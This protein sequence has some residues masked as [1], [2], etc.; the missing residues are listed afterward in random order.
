M[1][2]TAAA[3]CILFIGA[4]CISAQASEQATTD[5]TDVSAILSELD[6]IGL[7]TVEAIELLK[8]EAYAHYENKNWE[9]AIE[10]FSKLAKNANWLANLIR[11]GL[12]P[13]YGASYDERKEYPYSKLRPLVPIETISNGYIRLRNDAMV[14]EG[15][16]YANLSEN[17]KAVSLLYKALDLIDIENEEL[18][19][20]AREALFKIIG[21][22]L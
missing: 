1:K 3:L 8:K 15:L 11:S 22:T 10:A 19:T 14:K 2:T 6:D 18:W 12:E 5:P 17:S 4:S 21:V 7:P 9:L 20:E 13:Y 16:C